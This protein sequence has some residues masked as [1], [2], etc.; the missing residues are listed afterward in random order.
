MIF[1]TFR[2]FSRDP[3]VSFLTGLFFSNRPGPDLSN[4]VGLVSVYA[5]WKKLLMVQARSWVRIFE[6][7]SFLYGAHVL[8]VLETS[9]KSY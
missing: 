9:L 8:E 5:L 2:G 1:D 6:F 3:V 4:G 7:S